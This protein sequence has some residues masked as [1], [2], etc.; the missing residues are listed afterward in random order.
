MRKG[1]LFA[2]V[3][4][5]LVPTVAKAAS[6]QDFVAAYAAAERVE[7]QAMALQNAWTTTEGALRA[8]KEA[9]AAEHYHEAVALAR[10][11]EAMA[12]VSVAEA[13]EQR[14]LWRD[15]VVH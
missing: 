15:A 4:A 6:R 13:K 1:V 14:V 2:A 11:A 3:A 12:R 5:L 9:A 10:K 8:A 7:Q